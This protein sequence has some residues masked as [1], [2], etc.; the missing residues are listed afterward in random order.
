MTGISSW[1]LLE[2]GLLLFNLLF[3]GVAARFLA[4]RVRSKMGEVEQRHINRTSSLYAD[5]SE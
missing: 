3:I 2:W 1:G 4:H 5:D